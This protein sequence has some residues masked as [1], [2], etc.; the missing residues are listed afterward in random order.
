M[1]WAVTVALAALL[2]GCLAPNRGSLESAVR[3]KVAIGM[4]IPLAVSQ[5]SELNLVCDN[6]NPGDLRPV[7]CTRVMERLPHSCTEHVTLIVAREDY[8]VKS[9]EVPPITCG[10][11]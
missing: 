10:G 7:S 1:R 8:S 2:A 5:L 11:S 9:I 4:P 6:D 3:T